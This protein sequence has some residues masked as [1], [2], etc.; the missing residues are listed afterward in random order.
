[1]KALIFGAGAQGR[2]VLDILRAQG[3]HESVEFVDD[4]EQLWGQRVNGIP[5][6]GGFDY[7]LQ[8]D[9]ETFE[10][11]VAL[12]NP[13]TRLTIAKKAK[14]HS[15]HLLN[16]VHPSAVIMPSATIGEGNM[17]SPAAVINSNAR[18]GNNVIINTG[19]VIEHDCILADGISVSP[20]A[21]LGGRVTVDRV[22]FISTRA[23]VVPRIS[24]GA[25]AIIGAG[26]VVTKDVPARVLVRGM[27]ARIV[28]QINETFDWKRLL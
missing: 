23:I 27:P 2:V 15:I 17:I 14:E 18:I 28:E 19:A 5:I 26:A 8:Q 16:A 24:I 10:M 21:H 11:V 7:I 22:A 1:M 4:N 6:V 20:G 9:R 13:N 25:G 3:R 12:G